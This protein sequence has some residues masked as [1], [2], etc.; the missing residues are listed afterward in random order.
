MKLVMQLSLRNLWRQRR[1]NFLLV[2]AI[3]LAVAGV[4]LLNG[5]NRGLQDDMRSGVIENLT[6][7]FKM[8]TPRF[9]DNPSMARGFD[10][11]DVLQFIGQQPSMSYSARISVPSVILSER[12]TRG[13]SLVGLDPTK[14]DISFYSDIVIEG[15][16]L[17][18]ESDT[19]VLIGRELAGELN[20]KVGRRLVLIT[21]GEDQASREFGYRVSGIYDSA[22]NALERQFVFTGLQALQDRLDTVKVTEVS[23]RFA[24]EDIDQATVDLFK[25]QFPELEVLTWRDINKIASFMYDM[26]E[27]SIGIYVVVVLFTLVFGITNTMITAIMERTREFGLFRAVGMR[28]NLI[29]AQVVT[30]SITI[31]ILGL[32]IGLALGGV[33]V[34]WLKDGI[35]LSAFTSMTETWGISTRLKPVLIAQDLITTVVVSFVLA[36]VASLYPARRAVKLNPLEALTRT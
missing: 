22:N 9:A 34:Y 5:F 35:D 25:A 19:R 27:I 18:G 3:V 20:A 30:E 31:M 26:L 36:V 1:R 24:T 28:P 4:I 16:A 23:V 8:T 21:Q 14:E 32:V 33:L 15:E 17:N 7:H 13:A 29:L 2:L 11:G 10:A 6:G 12:E